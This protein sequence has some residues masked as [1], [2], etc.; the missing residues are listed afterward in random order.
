MI[1]P[2]NFADRYIVFPNFS[3]NGAPAAGE[4]AFQKQRSHRWM[5]N[6]TFTVEGFRLT[7]GYNNVQWKRKTAAL[8]HQLK[9]ERSRVED[10]EMHANKQK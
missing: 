1:P 6:L 4:I 3:K 10:Q 9:P 7:A 2:F 5:R 8:A